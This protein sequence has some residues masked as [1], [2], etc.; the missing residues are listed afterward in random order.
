MVGRV[1]VASVGQEVE[2]AH[3]DRAPRVERLHL[4]V[5]VHAVGRHFIQL[6]LRWHGG[7]HGGRCCA[8]VGDARWVVVGCSGPTLMIG[9]EPMVSHTLAC[10]RDDGGA[11]AAW[12][13]REAPICHYIMAT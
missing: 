4:D 7:R 9:V 2:A 5:H 1:V 10:T 6:R 12:P 11:A 3:L 13:H 8:V